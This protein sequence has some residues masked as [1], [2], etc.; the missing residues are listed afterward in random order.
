MLVDQMMCAYND[1][2]DDN[3]EFGEGDCLSQLLE[4]QSLYLNQYL[5]LI[6]KIFLEIHNND[7]YYHQE[8]KIFKIFH[9]TAEY[10][11]RQSSLSPGQRF[12]PQASA[13]FAS[14]VN[15]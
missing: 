4:Y 1:K 12:R 7:A 11:H 2:R 5:F 8:L 9:N 13:L 6:F 10:H 15:N 14:C 3:S